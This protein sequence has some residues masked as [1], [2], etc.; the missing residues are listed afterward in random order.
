MPREESLEFEA[1]LLL[2]FK[3]R[4]HKKE[5]KG[6][7]MRREQGKIRGCLKGP[8]ERLVRDLPQGSASVDSGLLIG[9]H[10]HTCWLCFSSAAILPCSVLASLSNPDLSTS[11]VL[12]L[13]VLGGYRPR[14]VQ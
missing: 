13:V 1:S 9:W 10:A 12:G 3:S 4:S 6:G 2:Y 8:E 7:E 14:H 5:R 11:L